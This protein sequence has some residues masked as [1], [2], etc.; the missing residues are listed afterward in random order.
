MKNEY[1]QHEG[2]EISVE[3]TSATTCK[4]WLESLPEHQRSVKPGSVKA[5]ARDLKANRWTFNGATICFDVTG[6][7]IDGQHRL[8][9]FIEADEFPSVIVVKGLTA[10]SYS[11]IDS[12]ISRTYSDA[13]KHAGIPNYAGASSACN[14]WKTY[15]A[16]GSPRNY[17][18]SKKELLESYREHE[19]S[20]AWAFFRW[21]S[22]EGI[23]SQTR[24]VFL[25]S[26][27]YERMGQEL[28]TSFF[29]AL[30]TSVGSQSAIAFRKVLVRESNKNRGKIPQDEIIALG[31]KAMKAHSEGR[32]LKVLK[33]LPGEPLA[34]F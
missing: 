8:L 1:L 12:G 32:Q 2:A 23:I 7:L 10:E 16:G 17:R 3:N 14:A 20:I 27:G 21:A 11:D 6:A 24:R 5:L 26:Y 25:G 18:S 33:W 30:E 15:G 9:A 29:N 28:T 4:Q 13:F 34:S 22:I 31:L 19:E